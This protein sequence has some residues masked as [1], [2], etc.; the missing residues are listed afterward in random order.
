METLTADQFQQKYGVIAASQFGQDKKQEGLFSEIKNAFA[1]GV[2][3]AEQGFQQIGNEGGAGL[4]PGV[5][6]IVGG[7]T[8]AITSPAAPILN[9]TVQPA[10]NAIAD[11]VSDSPA[12]QKFAMSPAGQKTAD[13][14]ATFANYG[15]AA[16]LA[17]GLKGGGSLAAKVPEVAGDVAS[18][19]GDAMPDA[20]GATKYVKGAV[21]DIVPT[22]QNLIDS[23]LAKGLDL[24]N[25]DL[26]NITSSTGNE[27]GRWLSDNNLIGT[28]KATTQNLIKGFF[29]QNYDAVR[30]AIKSVKKVYTPEQIPRMVNMLKRI[31]GDIGSI[32]GLEK[33]TKEVS[34]LVNN[35]EYTLS[36]VQRAKEI[37]DD[38]YKLY[39]RSG[40]LGAGDMKDGLANIRG[41]IKSFI[42]TEVKRETGQDIGKMNNNV[43]TARELGDMIEARSQRGLT[44]THLNNRDITTGLGLSYFGTPFVGLA[45]VLIKKVA[46]SP[47]MRLRLARYLDGL[48]DAER[49]KIS[50]SLK[51]GDVPK[52]IK[53]IVPLDGGEP[54]I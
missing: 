19:V 50:E 14:A 44:R 38:R 21:R 22:K 26:G 20:S 18:K 46:E 6:K 54:P 35:T 8:E 1:G 4:V 53:N 15:E 49:A 12:V 16:G 3:K 47:T 51:N 13:T 30:S 29:Q 25:G 52:E 43:A 39:S 37:F 34:N 23:S 5:G 41:D 27:V 24:T 48:N 40:E 42:E 11:R 45:Y 31:Q 9:R 32:P 17:T 7:A 28:N 33:E 10:I 2:N 36:D